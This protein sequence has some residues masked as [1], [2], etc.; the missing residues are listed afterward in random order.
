M[1]MKKILLKIAVLTAFAVVAGV[2]ATGCKSS[3]QVSGG[4]PFDRGGHESPCN[5]FDDETYF[6]ATGI[7]S[8]PATQKG[9]LQLT[10]LSNG[11][12][13]IRRKMEHAYE[14]LV[15]DFMEH[16]GGNAGSDV[17]TQ[18]IGGGKQV[19]MRIVND[20]SHHC[21]LY[22]GVDDKGNV[23]CYIGIRISKRKVADAVANAVTGNLSKNEKEA[24]RQHAEEFGKY[25][26]E[27]LKK[28]RGE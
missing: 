17:E 8:G 24:I 10:A 15:K 23:E 16:I 25:A 1:I 20:A 3:K 21:L 4:N 5:T 19:I 9:A 11:Q 7:A 27:Y 2:M 12:N 18:T 22:S 6:G 13:M 26:D 14:G 28:Y